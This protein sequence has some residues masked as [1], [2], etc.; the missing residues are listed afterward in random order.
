MVR[1]TGAR[2]N[3]WGGAGVL[4]ATV[5][6]LGTIGV[7]LLVIDVPA[8][9]PNVGSATIVLPHRRL[10]PASS[11]L[12]PP[13]EG[14]ATST[15]G[16]PVVTWV[17][18]NGTAFPG[19]RWS[20]NGTSPTSLAVDGTDATLW[21]GYN[22]TGRGIAPNVTAIDL[23]GPPS[24][25]EVAST[26]NVTALLYDAGA[27]RMYAAE[28]RAGTTGWVGVLN[29]SS[30]LPVASP[31]V[32]GADPIALA[33]DP[34][35]EELFVV[36]SG[37]ANGNITLVSTASLATRTVTLP[38]Q[39][40]GVGV[41]LAGAAYDPDDG[42]VYALG[43]NASTNPAC[44]GTYVF[45][46]NGSTGAPAAPVITSLGAAVGGTPS[47][48]FDPIDDLV[49]VL[50]PDAS[51]FGSALE[52]VDPH[53]ESQVWYHSIS[54]GPET[55]I[56]S[57]LQVDP[58][59]GD[60]L[61]VAENG[62]SLAGGG[63]LGTIGPFSDGAAT[64]TSTYAGPASSCQ[65]YDPSLGLDFVGHGPGDY[66]SAL[67]V[68]A[69]GAPLPVL[70]LGGTP[71]SAAYDPLAGRL[72][73]AMS[74]WQSGPGFNASA[75]NAVALLSPIGGP[76]ATVVPLGPASATTADVA[77]GSGP[78]AVAFD[79][80]TDSLLVADRG[81]TNATVL[82]A[83]TGR[84][85]GPAAIA[86]RAAFDLADPAG[87]VVYFG[88][89]SGIV[90]WNASLGAVEGRYAVPY[91]G[92]A[93]ASFAPGEDLAVGS[94]PGEVYFLPEDRSC[95]GN[96]GYIRWNSSSSASTLFDPGA[97]WG[98]IAY[99]PSDGL[100]YFTD[101]ANDSLVAVDPADGSI[102]A[103]IPVGRQPSYITY[104]P[105]GPWMLVAD[106]GSA[107]LTVVNASS[108]AA[109]L[110]AHGSLFVG[111]D[112]TA[113]AVDTAQHQLFVSEGP[114]GSV[115]QIGAIPVISRFSASP[116]VGDVGTPITLSAVVSGG[117]SPL[118]YAY[119]GLPAGCASSGQPLSTCT[120]SENGT[121]LV[122]V[123]VTDAL[124]ITASA[125]TIVRVNPALEVNVTATP[126]AADAPGTV[127][128]VASASNGTPPYAYTWS[129]GDG[130]SGSGSAIAHLYADAGAFAPTVNVLDAAGAAIRASVTVEVAG[131]MQLA[132]SG[133]PT[134]ALVG[135]LLTWTGNVSGGLAPYGFSWNF[136][137]GTM[138]NTSGFNGS[139]VEHAY[140]ASGTYSVELEVDDSGGATLNRSWTLLVENAGPP[141]AAVAPF[142]TLPLAVG[143]ADA[144]L[145]GIVF[146]LWRRRRRDQL[147]PPAPRSGAG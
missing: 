40:L 122:T 93:N 36:D 22:A 44:A 62:P 19:L 99:D 35:S 125:S 131:G 140:N 67:N 4:L 81:S 47:I 69:G 27:G 110:S 141:S 130:G 42:D 94:S 126:A 129:F 111:A 96:G 71:Y 60:L 53:L 39:A 59:S 33:L 6:L 10:S 16:T 70:L 51:A 73:V 9:A 108:L 133:P 7:P 43:F 90:A 24:A 109:G 80:S 76:N 112:P 41:S 106:A 103:T 144:L 137:D 78:D 134:P 65:V 147:L 87:G 34:W 28:Y 86:M 105:N 127:N 121:F 102:V 88:G 79:P 52:A 132:G 29:G 26:P 68:T 97:P 115:V 146:L 135:T 92:C 66:V 37:P 12:A 32:V 38:I 124:G 18:S 55:L 15:I 101:R 2:R 21:A 48:V 104:D 23:A 46:L 91:P 82:N 31:V 100:L 143:G 11:P 83:T 45:V 57:S 63:Y 49:F 54:A 56:A 74:G 114:S 30:H 13:G 64:M 138:L 136:G 50:F 107:N 58:G 120:P 20:R 84:V 61:F 14:G 128:F 72:V 8:P 5:S 119:G 113:I 123:T 25:A 95:G 75:P 116:A 139:R 1:A 145:A 3:G 89:P 142:P 17:L 98:A 118:Q 117:T 77:T 85:S